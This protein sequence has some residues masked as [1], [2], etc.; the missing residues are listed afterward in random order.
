MYDIV[1]A[2]G[3][4]DTPFTKIADG[5]RQFQ[6]EIVL[7]ATWS[8]RPNGYL[9]A[10]HEIGH[11]LGLKHP[12]EG[13]TL[14]NPDEDNTNNTVMSY[15]D[16]AVTYTLKTYDI[17]AL[18]SIYGPAKAR[19]GNNSYKFGNDEIIWD[20][21]GA[22]TIT[23]AHLREKIVLDLAG[24]AHN[25]IRKKSASILDPD[26]IWLG[27]FTQIENAIGGSG[28]D[29][30]SG[31]EINNSTRGGKGND[32]I[33]G[34]DGNDTLRGETGADTLVGG[35]GADRLFGGKDPS[36]DVF[37]F[38]AADE[39][40]TPDRHDAVFDFTKLDRLDFRAF[41]ADLTAAG[42]QKLDFIGSFKT[43]R[44]WQEAGTAYYNTRTDMLVF[45]TDG[46]GIADHWLTVKGVSTLKDAYFIL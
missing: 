39:L 7:D 19:L 29:A 22:D 9:H 6:Q 38:R 32:R 31:N 40:G 1:G 26:Q 42:Q 21:G 34:R 18:Q 11:A 33:N 43:D 4:A 10:L 3:Y 46:D 8:T 41:D 14:L 27:H 13:E 12:F 35:S 20:G 23:A 16:T 15:T 25:Y 28:N 37:V 24:G 2:E 5:A 44:A 36:K 45:E 17:I 30:I